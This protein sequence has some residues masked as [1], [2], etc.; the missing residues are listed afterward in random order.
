MIVI[1]ILMIVFVGTMI[2]GAI[3]MFVPSKEV[4]DVIGGISFFISIVALVV[5]FFYS[6]S[7]E[8][9]M[10]VDIAKREEFSLIQKDLPYGICQSIGMALSKLELLEMQ[11]CK[12]KECAE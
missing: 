8:A 4:I 10:R 5:L 7:F 12:V 9:K 1:E 2:L 11:G 3:L 6:D